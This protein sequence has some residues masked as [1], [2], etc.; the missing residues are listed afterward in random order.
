MDV[1]VVSVPKSNDQKIL[2]ERYP[3][4]QRDQTVNLAA[5][6][7]EGSNPSLSTI[8]SLVPVQRCSRLSA[9]VESSCRV[10]DDRTERVPQNFLSALIFQLDL[11]I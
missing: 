3:S 10:S 1:P 11:K 4:G 2:L 9:A 8:F 6:A 5:F 7:F